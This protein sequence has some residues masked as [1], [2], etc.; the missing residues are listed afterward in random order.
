MYEAQT[1]DAWIVFFTD[2]SCVRDY[3]VGTNRDLCPSLQSNIKY[4]KWTR[5]LI[6][7]FAERYENVLATVKQNYAKSGVIK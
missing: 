3:Q 4:K 7:T 5:P 6:I 2:F 1:P